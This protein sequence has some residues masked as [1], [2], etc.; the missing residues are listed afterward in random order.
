MRAAA[1][2]DQTGAA[3]GV[4]RRELG[5]Q[6]MCLGIG[7]FDATGAMMAEARP[8]RRHTRTTLAEVSFACFVASAQWA[9]AALLGAGGGQV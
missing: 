3:E 1:L 5:A 4:D 6:A 8:G 2:P 9:C 7:E